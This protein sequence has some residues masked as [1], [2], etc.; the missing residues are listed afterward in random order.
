MIW[1]FK[2]CPNVDKLSNLVTLGI[3]YLPLLIYPQKF[4]TFWDEFVFD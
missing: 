2:S 1:D 3:I 4:E